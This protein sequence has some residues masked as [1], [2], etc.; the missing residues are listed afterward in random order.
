MF[1]NAYNTVVKRG[2]Q[3]VRDVQFIC[4]KLILLN[5]FAFFFLFFNTSNPLEVLHKDSFYGFILFEN[6]GEA[7]IFNVYFFILAKRL[8]KFFVLFPLK[9]K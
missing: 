9:T 7:N 3:F 5:L 1:A 6:L 2:I 8:M 4:T